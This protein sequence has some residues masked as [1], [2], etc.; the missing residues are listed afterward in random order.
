MRLRIV[1]EL[2]DDEL[3]SLWGYQH[4]EVVLPE[5]DQSNLDL[6]LGSAESI[7]DGIDV[8]KRSISKQISA[9]SRSIERQEGR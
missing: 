9:T 7:L 3:G 1:V 8:A 4:E 5:P 2:S 6:A